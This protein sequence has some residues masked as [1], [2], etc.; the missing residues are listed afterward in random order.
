MLTR[1]DVWDRIVEALAK[2]FGFDYRALR[3]EHSEHVRQRVIAEF[4]DPNTGVE[5]LITS[6]QISSQ[7]LNLQDSCSDMIIVEPPPTIAMLVQLIAR[8]RRIGQRRKCRVELLYLRDSF[9]DFSWARAMTK[10]VR[11]WGGET[12]LRATYG[13]HG[14]A[15]QV[16]GAE[17]TRAY[18]GLPH[19]ALELARTSLDEMGVARDFC[20]A[21]R[22]RIHELF[23]VGQAQRFAQDMECAG[24]YREFVRAIFKRWKASS[25]KVPADLVDLWTRTAGRAIGCRPPLL[26]VEFAL[27]APAKRY[28]EYAVPARVEAGTVLELWYRMMERCQEQFF[29][30][31]AAGGS[32]PGTP[33]LASDGP[34]EVGG[35]T[36]GGI[37]GGGIGGVLDSGSEMDV[38]NAGEQ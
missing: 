33:A 15:L 29:A 23:D 1:A 35:G 28:L 2:T 5:V 17:L 24:K 9:D 19:V 21:L 27:T 26:D 31:P 16:M 3:A 34:M 22:G 25:G 36:G 12:A 7:G 14:A 18:L 13:G 6:T 10:H 11:T 38:D 8:I 30:R 37:G 4:R 20:V 32:I